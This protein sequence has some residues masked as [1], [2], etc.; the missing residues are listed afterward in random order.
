DVI[1]RFDK[2]HEYK[3][4]F[5]LLAL[6]QFF[7][8]TKTRIDKIVLLGT[9]GSMWDA[10]LECTDLE[11]REL[12]ETL[13]IAVQQEN[14]S[15][16]LLKK[17]NDALRKSL[18]IQII[19]KIIPPGADLNEQAKILAIIASEILGKKDHVIMD[20]THGYRSLPM[21]ELL[22]IFYLNQALDVKIDGIYY[23]ARDMGKKN[24]SGQFCAPV[25]RLD[26]ILQML[27]WLNALP[28]VRQGGRY[29]AIAELLTDQEVIQDTLKKLSLAQHLN[30]I[31][32]AV[33]EAEHFQELLQHPFADNPSAELFRQPLLNSIHWVTADGLPRQMLLNASIACRQG[34][35]L[36][37]VILVQEARVSMHLKPE[38]Y[39]NL[40]LRE[41]AKVKLNSCTEK[42]DEILDTLRNVLAHAT[43][44]DKKSSHLQT[45]ETIIKDEEALKGCIE[46]LIEYYIEKQKELN[47][48]KDS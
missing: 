17:L 36:R 25:V 18:G 23:G 37:S 5:F 3:G 45:V 15:D 43:V 42:E 26:F 28:L 48:N 11:D 2:E 4:T 44:P 20:V 39:H 1:Y 35:Y 8:D 32:N 10:L 16:E 6:N 27:K 34:D 21:L 29:D 38:D 22:A 14:V 40:Q 12:L 31:E 46:H 19:C 30:Q 33:P 47:E 7:N 13:P 41:K 9:N 24:D